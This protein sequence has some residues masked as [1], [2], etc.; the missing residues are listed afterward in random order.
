MEAKVG[1]SFLADGRAVGDDRAVPSRN[2]HGARRV[3]DRRV[4][5]GIL[6][7]LKT[8]SR[9]CD[10]PEAYGP[11]ATVYNRF[12]RWSRRRFWM[13]LLEGQCQGKRQRSSF[14]H[15]VKLRAPCMGRLVA[16]SS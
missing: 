7:V 10:C 3:D 9:W 13:G 14:P 2:Q 5:S 1:C 8:G 6:H 12:N 15:F 11:S 4:I 16:A